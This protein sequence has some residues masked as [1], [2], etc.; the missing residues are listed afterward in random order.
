MNKLISTL[1]LVFYTTT[2]I[3]YLISTHL[4]AGEISSIKFHTSN[5]DTTNCGCDE[6]SEKD[7][8]CQDEFKNFKLDTE[9]KKNDKQNLTFDK[10]S[11]HKISTE[12]SNNFF[13]QDPQVL[14]LKKNTPT[15][16]TSLQKLYC[17]YLI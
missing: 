1:V 8:C 17:T 16:L 5:S 11:V 7:N 3:G 10:K 6:K 15:K 13:R 12:H 2:S 4:C 9:Q 14:F